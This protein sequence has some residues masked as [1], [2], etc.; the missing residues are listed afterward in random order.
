M[1]M[2]HDSDQYTLK[3]YNQDS[4]CIFK[5]VSKYLDNNSSIE[6]KIVAIIDD[7]LMKITDEIQQKNKGN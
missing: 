2:N 1:G 3:I 5:S 4:I 7:A 6:G